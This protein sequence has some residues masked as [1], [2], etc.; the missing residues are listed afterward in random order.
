MYMEAL[1]KHT[2]EATICWE[3][4]ANVQDNNYLFDQMNYGINT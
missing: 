3:I 1:V 2:K 4:V